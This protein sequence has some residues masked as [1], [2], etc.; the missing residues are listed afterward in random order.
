[1][2]KEKNKT[3]R[4]YNQDPFADISDTEIPAPQVDSELQPN[5]A[6]PVA[7]EGNGVEHPTLIDQVQAVVPEWLAKSIAQV[8]NTSAKPRMAR[9]KK[10]V[11]AKSSLPELPAP[12]PTPSDMAMEMPD[13]Q[14]ELDQLPIIQYLAT[15]AGNQPQPLIETANENTVSESESTND[16]NAFLQTL[17]QN[18]NALFPEPETPPET[19]PQP[20]TPIE[21]PPASVESASA[22][23]TLLENLIDQIDASIQNTPTSVSVSQ[24]QL[25]TA[26]SSTETAQFI[27]FSLH[28][29]EYAVPLSN[30]I[31]IERPPAIT[32]V[33]NM[34]DWMMGVTNLRGD[35]VSMVD[36]RRFLGVGQFGF[37]PSARVLM[38]QTQTGEVTIGFLVDRVS[39]VRS[40]G[41]NQIKSPTAP[42]ED[43]IATFMRG[44]YEYENRMI[45][46]LDF[47]KLL[48]S[49][50]IRQ[51]ETA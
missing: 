4:S 49:T 51:F 10:S 20:E 1:M 7:A 39:G 29:T 31:E 14:V 2:G 33:P 26:A 24:I 21:L 35:I 5:P 8:T 46:V 45:V 42:I 18:S 15:Q 11:P 3:M 9:K 40:L 43:R 47:N 6:E 44:I 16:L 32:L 17:A 13:L 28:K 38:A 41:V 19:L 25:P 48:L 27:V 30:V 50:E 36:L 22:S 37:T 23:D 34:P 12:E